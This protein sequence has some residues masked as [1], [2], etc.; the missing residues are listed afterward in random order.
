MKWTKAKPK[1]PE[2]VSRKVPP[3]PPGDVWTATVGPLSVKVE[4]KGDGRWAWSI[5][6]SGAPNPT[7]TGI[8]SSASAAKNV[9]EQYVLRSGHE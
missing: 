8:A 7:A 1:P 3:T 9:V 4:P 6:A 5:H 2:K